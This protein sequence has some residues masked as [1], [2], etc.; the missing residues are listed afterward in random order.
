MDDYSKQTDDGLKELN[1][2]TEEYYEE[3]RKEDCFIEEEDK[4]K[5]TIFDYIRI[6]LI[7]ISYAIFLFVDIMD[8]GF[9]LMAFAIFFFTI[10]TFFLGAIKKFF[11]EGDNCSLLF[12]ASFFLRVILLLFFF[13]SLSMIFLTKNV[14]L[15]YT[16]WI[17]I[18]S[19]LTI[20]S[21]EVI[22][23]MIEDYRKRKNYGLFSRICR[24]LFN[25]FLLII[26]INLIAMVTRMSLPENGS[27]IVVNQLKMPDRIEIIK[28]CNNSSYVEETLSDNMITIT[29]Q[30]FHQQLKAELEN[31]NYEPMNIIS[32]LNYIKL[33][34]I[35]PVYYQLN[36]YYNKYDRDNVF[37]S[38]FTIITIIDDKVVFRYNNIRTENSLLKNT[39]NDY[40]YLE[41]SEETRN[42]L[43]SYIDRLE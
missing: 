43:Y 18:F 38:P 13:V 25:I 23:S 8:Q 5:K 27:I 39:L 14:Y 35:T 6:G 36:L 9:A 32:E 19:F 42:S 40:Y 16:Y 22:E 33:K 37:A 34:H 21:M 29:D 28:V 4:P 1:T 7:L 24:N 10:A 41:L 20:A 15:N 31:K 3:K 30:T 2:V 12:R 17:A 26:W 11:T